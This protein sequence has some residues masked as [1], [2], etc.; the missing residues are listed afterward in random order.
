M[1]LF[2]SSVAVLSCS[3]VSAATAVAD[4]EANKQIVRRFVN[5]IWNK[6]NVKLADTLLAADFVRFGPTSRT[7]VHGRDA[8]KEYVTKI[9]GAYTNFK[10]TIDEV[11]AKANTATLRWTV[12]G[13]FT[14]T[15]EIV[16]TGNKKVNIS[17]TSMYQLA[18]GK[19][20]EVRVSWDVLD[21]Y[22][23]VG[24]DPLPDQRQQDLTTV[25]RA[26]TE[27]YNKGNTAAINEFFTTSVIGHS[28]GDG[29]TTTGITAFRD[30]VTKA[31]S[32]FPDLYLT[33]D[34]MVFEQGKVVVRWTARGTQKGEYHGLAPTNKIVK[35]GGLTMYRLVNGKIAET[36]SGWDRGEL[37]RQLGVE[38]PTKKSVD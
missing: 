31:R 7:S 27:M 18:G 17:G 6:G 21:W 29:E 38:L 15:D 37:F 33:V 34:D 16:V 5:E 11:T 3:L 30:G 19:I 1:K 13:T 28:L 32:A 26:I 10:V 22:R 8:L 35:V 2:L 23:Q 25:R 14:G 12:T 24:V 36:W 20:V 9:R 4:E